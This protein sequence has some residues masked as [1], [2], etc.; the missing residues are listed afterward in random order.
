M[1]SDFFGGFRYVLRGFGLMNQPGLRRYVL[2]P[3]AINVLLFSLGLWYLGSQFE[4][5]LSWMLPDWLDWARWLLWPIFA[6][7]A[8]LIVFYTFTLL[9]NFVGAPFNSLLAAKLE[10][11][12][13]GQAPPEGGSLRA[14]M[15]GLGKSLAG[16][17]L[18]LGYL[19]LWMIPLLIL[20]LIPGLN[21]LAPLA[22]FAF[23]AWMLSIEYADFPM[24]NHEMYFK[25]ERALMRRNKPLALGFGAGLMLMTLVPV[26]N[27][28]AMPVGVTGATALWAERLKNQAASPPSGSGD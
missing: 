21:L 12:L 5:L 2:A 4:A 24:G 8:L 3:L 14:V 16:E 28:L 25:Q 7:A 1:I 27:F 20:F 26:L 15:L 10:E 6:V 22:W 18:K 17:A 13:T 11:H 23:G 19:A 9:A